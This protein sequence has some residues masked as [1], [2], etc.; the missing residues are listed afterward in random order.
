MNYISSRVITRSA[1]DVLFADLGDS[2][3]EILFEDR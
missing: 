1:T 2:T 3:S